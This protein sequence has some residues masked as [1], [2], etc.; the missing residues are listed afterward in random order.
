M[1][2]QPGILLLYHA[3]LFGRRAENLQDSIRSFSQYSVFPVHPVNTAHPFPPALVQLS[4]QVVLFHYTLFGLGYAYELPERYLEVIARW[5][6]VY[7]VAQ[8]QDEFRYCGKRF[9]FV[10]EQ[11]I[12]TVYTLA[13]HESSE[14]GV[15][16][17]RTGARQVI[18]YLASYV[19]E[20]LLQAARRY[21]RP[22]GRRTLDIGYRARRQ[23]AF[24]GRGGWEKHAIGERFQA[25]CQ[26]RHLPLT[27]DL[28]SRERD[29]LYGAAWWR[30][31]AN[32]RGSLG[33][34]SGSGI[35]DVEDT[36]QAAT[37][38]LL[39]Q[40]PGIEF[41]TLWQRLLRPYEDAVP[42]RFVAPRNF[43]CAAF[44]VCQILYEGE[45]SGVV[46]PWVHY[47]P[48]RKDF[49]NFDAVVSAFRDP[50]T[51]DELCR[52]AERDLVGSGRYT[53][54]AF[55]ASF[56]AHL[57]AQGVTPPSAGYDAEPVQRALAQRPLGQNL[58][59]HAR[60]LHFAHFPGKK[61]L[62]ILLRRP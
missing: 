16:R 26:A 7:R 37:E 45:Y 35:F 56:D 8:F 27:L 44:G 40:E 23:A 3:P 62:R 41:E 12:D 2:R 21:R 5:P 55:V 4:F 31:L 42:Y 32:S 6:E 10:D 38:A 17:Q 43:E 61:L 20:G 34:E 1:S 28:S 11:A 22:M 54:Q 33:V 49:A 14:A 48:L 53:F 52:N 9:R 50:A 57:R 15:Y 18:P 60:D 59:A 47:L 58:L 29:R 30:F 25:A 13:P 46:Q 24:M 51:R 36:L 39:A 19:S